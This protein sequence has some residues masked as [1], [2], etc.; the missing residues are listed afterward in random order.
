MFTTCKNCKRLAYPTGDDPTA[1]I[2]M[3]G[4]VYR[5]NGWIECDHCKRRWHGEIIR[6]MPDV[7]RIRVSKL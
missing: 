2:S 3:Q 5:Y 6:I 1:T 4:D 7:G